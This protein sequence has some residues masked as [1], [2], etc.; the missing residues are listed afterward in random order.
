MQKL[1]SFPG[2]EKNRKINKWGAFIWYLRVVRFE[3]LDFKRPILH[4]Y[5]GCSMYQLRGRQ[6]NFVHRLF[7]Y[8]YVLCLKTSIQKRSCFLR[9]LARLFH[10]WLHYRRIYRRGVKGGAS[11]NIFLLFDKFCNI[12]LALGKFQN[13]V[14]FAVLV[15][16][17]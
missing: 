5:V 1:L 17:L 11:P 9:F 15:L 3:R 6:I 16:F 10:I 8:G 4:H 7:S 14:F 12:V 2:L 13:L